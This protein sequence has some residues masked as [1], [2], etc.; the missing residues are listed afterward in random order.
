MR[1][2]NLHRCSLLVLITSA[3]SIAPIYAQND[4][5]CKNSFTNTENL[6]IIY[7]WPE[8]F[9]KLKLKVGEYAEGYS[10][11]GIANTT[12]NN[13]AP[14]SR[15]SFTETIN[16]QPF[17]IFLK[18]SNQN[19]V[20]VKGKRVVSERINIRRNSNVIRAI[21]GIETESVEGQDYYLKTLDG[22]ISSKNTPDEPWQLHFENKERYFIG[23]DVLIYLT[24]QNRKIDILAIRKTDGLDDAKSDD[25]Q[26]L[27]FKENE[28]CLAKVCNLSIDFNPMIDIKTKNVIIAVILALDN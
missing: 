13:S 22:T 3:I 24:C 7:K 9:G 19:V 25:C 10:K 23:S 6:E 15:T 21:T 17:R 28:T 1:K 11:M 12:A 14:A 2:I 4:L 27:V 26:T 16:T 8:L 18:D 5:Y 20:Q